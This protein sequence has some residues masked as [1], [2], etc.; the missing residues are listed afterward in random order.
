M[1]EISN[2]HNCARNEKHTFEISD[3]NYCAQNYQLKSSSIR[4]CSPFRAHGGTPIFRAH[5]GARQTQVGARFIQHKCSKHN[6][7]LVMIAQGCV[8]Q[9]GE[10]YHC[11]DKYSEEANNE[12]LKC[13]VF[14]NFPSTFGLPPST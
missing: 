2:Y 7:V 12:H 13:S 4:M 1:L 14:P 11:L 6:K 3:N 8:D 5:R 9:F 10:H